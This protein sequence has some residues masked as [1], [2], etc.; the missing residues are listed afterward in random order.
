MASFC[1]AAPDDI[2][3]EHLC[4]FEVFPDDLGFTSFRLPPTSPGSLV[5]SIII[6]MEYMDPTRKSMVYLSTSRG[7]L[8]IYD[9]P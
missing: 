3:L 8:R 7:N 1:R 6:Y 4:N 2:G 9:I 5:L